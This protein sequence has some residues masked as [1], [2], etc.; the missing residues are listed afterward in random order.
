MRWTGESC[1]EKGVKMIGGGCVRPCSG[2]GDGLTT[3]LDD[4]YIYM[5]LLYLQTMNAD[6]KREGK[7]Q[8]V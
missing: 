2:R 3:T 6:L 8:R 4:I 5:V 1:P 7:M